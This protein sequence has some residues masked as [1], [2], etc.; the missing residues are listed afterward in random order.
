M[1]TAVDHVLSSDAL[2][3]TLILQ[4]RSVAPIPS[5]DSQEI[6]SRVQTTFDRHAAQIA[7]MREEFGN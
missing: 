4:G 2:A 3:D 1:R 6:F 5:L 7:E